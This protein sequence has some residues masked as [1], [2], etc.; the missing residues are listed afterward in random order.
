MLTIRDLCLEAGGN[1]LVDGIDLAVGEGEMLGL[2]GESGCGKTITALSV[3]GLLPSHA[4]RLTRGHILFNG[5]D[6]AGLGEDEMNAVRGNDISMIFQEPMTSLNPVMTVG[7][8]I[9]EGLALHRALD[10]AARDAEVDRLLALVGLP[11]GPAQR[12]KYPHQLSGGQR[13]R[14]MIAMALACEPALLI[15]DEPTTALDVTIQ[16]QILDLIGEMR[17]RFGMACILVTHDLGVVAETCGAVAVMYAGRIVEQ[18]PVAEVFRTPRHRY[19]QA[20]LSTIPAANRPGSALPAIPGT[21][22][23]PGARPP[24]CAFAERCAHALSRCADEKPPREVHGDHVAL[25]W[26]PAS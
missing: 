5:R 12:R 24:G 1:V 9:G 20:L 15:A 7:D 17:A 23:P 21:V 13:Q 26:N 2:V 6:L 3:L 25:C 22:P 14:V 10:G 8:Q 11:N 18:G 16:A 19:T 4:V